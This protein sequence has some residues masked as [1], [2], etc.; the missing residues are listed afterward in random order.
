MTEDELRAAFEPW[1]SRNHRRA[2]RPQPSSEGS[3]TWFGG[4]PVGSTGDSWLACSTCFAPMRFFLQ[5]DFD[6]IP[7]SALHKPTSSLL[8]LFY[9]STDDGTCETWRPHS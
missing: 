6:S 7:P 5:L 1:R 4:N 3:M 9:C 8:Q 2:W